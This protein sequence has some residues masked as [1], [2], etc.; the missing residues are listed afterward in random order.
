MY[1]GPL[2]K[3]RGPKLWAFSNI[4]RIRALAL[5]E[6]HRLVT[7]LH[8]RYGDIVRIG[9]NELSFASGSE[10]WKGIYGSKE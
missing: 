3:Y 2:S 7:E 5:G 9:P 1:L 8:K 6:E 4:P 10:T